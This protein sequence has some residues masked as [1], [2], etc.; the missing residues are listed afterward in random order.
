ML[1]AAI[2]TSFL[3]G[4]TV[5]PMAVGRGCRLVVCRVVCGEWEGVYICVCVCV[6][7]YIYK[8]KTAGGS[9]LLRLLSATKTTY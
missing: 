9:L 8:S 2:A 3:I 5:L 4:D 6:E 1:V 7:I